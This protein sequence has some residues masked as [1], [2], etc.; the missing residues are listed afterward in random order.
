MRIWDIDPGYLNRQS[1][2]GEHRELHGMV[3][4]IVNRKQGYANHPETRRWA[5]Y[6]WALKQRHD[7]LVAEMT[8][9]G[10]THH[11]PVRTRRHH[12][13][14]PTGFIDCPARQFEILRRKYIDKDPGR[15]PLPK[16]AQQLWAQHKYSVMARDQNLYRR[17]GRQVAGMRARRDFAELVNILLVSLRTRPDEGGI[18]NA[19]QHMWGHVGTDADKHAGIGKWNLS[20]LLKETRARAFRQKEIYLIHSTALGELASWLS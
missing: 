2:L 17:L 1:L 13:T 4:I 5:G 12:A 15:I 7:M 3:S 20:R 14:W 16:N 10:Y 11:T 6:G 8:L 18:R 9:R 19:L